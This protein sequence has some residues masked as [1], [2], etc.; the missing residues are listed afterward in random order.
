MFV[1][2][3]DEIHAVM[4]DAA[5]HMLKLDGRMANAK[6]VAQPALQRLENLRA[7]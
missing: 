6:F 2:V 1:L 5:I 7:G 4:Q 3:F